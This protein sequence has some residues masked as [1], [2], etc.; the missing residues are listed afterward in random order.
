[1]KLVRR[2]RLVDTRKCLCV[3]LTALNALKQKYESVDRVLFHI[4][5]VVTCLDAYNVSG[6]LHLPNSQGLCDFPPAM[7]DG[8]D[9]L[10]CLPGFF[11]RT[12]VT[13]QLALAQGQYP[14]KHELPTPL[15]SPTA[16][17]DQGTCTCVSNMSWDLPDLGDA[18]DE[19]MD[20]IAL[21]DAP[22]G[23]PPKNAYSEDDIV[24]K[25]MSSATAMESSGFSDLF[26]DV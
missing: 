22:Q 15:A 17:H 6:S 19:I 2:G 5:Q 18:F 16:S 11:L 26:R 14:E 25:P 24:G 12:V 4:R 21:G 7:E 3:Y 8:V 20:T 10:T 13:V 9:V 23:E 1:M